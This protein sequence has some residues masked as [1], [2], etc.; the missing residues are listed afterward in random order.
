MTRKPRS[1]PPREPVAPGGPMVGTLPPLLPGLVGGSE[2]RWPGSH[3]R[4][5]E[6]HSLGLRLRASG[7]PTLLGL[8]SFQRMTR[9]IAVAVRFTAAPLRGVCRALNTVQEFGGGDRGDAHGAL[10]TRAEGSSAEMLLAGRWPVQNGCE[11]RPAF[12]TAAPPCPILLLAMESA[13]TASAAKRLMT[14]TGAL[15]Q[16]SRRFCRRFASDSSANGLR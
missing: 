3:R 5:R 6:C 13:V 4:S 2:P 15:E 14:P 7:R 9:A 1:L 12:L 16:R 11:P 8:C 10:G